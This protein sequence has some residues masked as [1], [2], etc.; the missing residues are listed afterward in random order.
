MLIKE[1]IY[2]EIF[3]V[4]EE[5]YE[6]AE[7]ESMQ[8]KKDECCDLYYIVNRLFRDESLVKRR[9]GTSSTKCVRNAKSTHK[10][11]T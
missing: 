4:I 10:H 3:R 11:L 7:Q 9:T 6:D 8:D 2:N 5:L 1:W